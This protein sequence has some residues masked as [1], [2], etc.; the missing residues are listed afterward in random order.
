MGH[1]S[2][3]RP[4]DLLLRAPIRNQTLWIDP[5][6]CKICSLL[7]EYPHQPLDKKLFTAL[8]EVENS[9]IYNACILCVPVLQKCV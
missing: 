3:T 2:N 5:A 7:R 4:Q 1:S 9:K 8:D 6:P